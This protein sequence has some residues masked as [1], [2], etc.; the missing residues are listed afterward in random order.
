MTGR[1]E[2]QNAKQLKDYL[3][4]D[5]LRKNANQLSC[6]SRCREPASSIE[7]LSTQ[8][9]RENVSGRVH[10]AVVACTT[11]GT[12]PLSYSE[13]AHTFRT[14]GGIASAAR[15]HLGREFLID[16]QVHR[17]VPA[18]F[19]AELRPEHRPACIGNGF[20]H[21]CLCKAGR[22][23]VTDR[24]QRILSHNLGGCFV[25]EISTTVLNFGVNCLRSSPI[26]GSLSYGQAN[27]MT[28]VN[29]RCIYHVAVA[30]CRQRLQAEINSDRPADRTL[31]FC[32]FDIETDIPPPASIFDE[33]PAPNI[34]SGEWAPL[35]AKEP[36]S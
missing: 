15:A 24:D 36:E 22:L 19:V 8:R 16:V 12:L 31:G 4:A 11:F 30:A 1:A 25:D 27:L 33:R 17:S 7:T 21:P 32:N 9:E 28:P 26:A 2:D 6:L 34:V 29:A 18:G 20:C 35:A 3:T 10:V 5:G 23:D 14:A 13:R